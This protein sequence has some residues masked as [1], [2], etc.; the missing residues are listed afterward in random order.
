MSALR[1]DVQRLNHGKRS[2]EA[3][4]VA[5]ETAAQQWQQELAALKMLTASMLAQPQPHGVEGGAGLLQQL[6]GTESAKPGSTVQA[7]NS[8]VDTV[9][10]QK[11]SC[12]RIITAPLACCAFSDVHVPREQPCMQCSCEITYAFLLPALMSEN[13]S[14]LLRCQW[15]ASFFY[16]EMIPS[17]QLYGTCSVAAGTGTRVSQVMHM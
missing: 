11:G 3:R 7:S 6:E 16:I 2:A 10:Q 17:F 8:V 9:T 13:A 1:V 12:V 5:A 14:N 15:P 4:A